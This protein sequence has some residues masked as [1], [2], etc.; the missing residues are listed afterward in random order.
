VFDHGVTESQPHTPGP[1]YF[2]TV[3]GLRLADLGAEADA[4]FYTLI[5]VDVGFFL[6]GV[7]LILKILDRS[8]GT[9]IRAK[10]TSFTFFLINPHVVLLLFPFY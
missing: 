6:L 10:P 9:V 1:P 5:F 4:A 7:F 2:L 8:H 3:N